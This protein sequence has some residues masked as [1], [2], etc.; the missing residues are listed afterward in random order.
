MWPFRRTQSTVETWQ[1]V[2]LWGKAFLVFSADLVRK[3]VPIVDFKDLPVARS[4]VHQVLRRHLSHYSHGLPATGFED[5]RDHGVPTPSHVQ[6]SSR[7]AACFGG[8]YLGNSGPCGSFHKV[9]YSISTST[10]C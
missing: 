4:P 10:G 5:A 6:D 2:A 3:I 9:L 7:I 8:Y 1:L